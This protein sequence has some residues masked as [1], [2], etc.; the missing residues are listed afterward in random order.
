MVLSTDEWWRLSG[1]KPTHSTR[2]SWEDQS[3]WRD[4]EGREDWKEDKCDEGR[5]WNTQHLKAKSLKV[6]HGGKRKTKYCPCMSDITGCTRVGGNT[7]T[8]SLS[9]LSQAKLCKCALPGTL[10]SPTCVFRYTRTVLSNKGERETMG[11][12]KRT[13]THISLTSSK[14]PQSPGDSPRVKWSYR[15]RENI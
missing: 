5:S 8:H 7:H 3:K 1:S 11:L 10:S 4:Y 2:L 15:R 14:A 9:S 13:H 6:F 12:T